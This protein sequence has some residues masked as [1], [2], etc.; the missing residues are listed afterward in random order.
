MGSGL[1]RTDIF[2]TSEKSMEAS[3]EKMVSYESGLC[4]A[5][6]DRDDKIESRLINGRTYVKVDIQD[7]DANMDTIW[8]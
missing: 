6:K 3:N 4:D 2:Q 7:V 1:T 5:T 8:T